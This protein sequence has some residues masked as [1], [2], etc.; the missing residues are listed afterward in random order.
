MHDNLQL[1]EVADSSST[2]GSIRSIPPHL[3]DEPTNESD[4]VE[5]IFRHHLEHHYDD[6][7]RLPLWFPTAVNLGSVGYIRHGQFI[8]LLDAHQP[9]LGVPSI[10]GDQVRSGTGGMDVD[11]RLP[12]RAFMSEFESLQTQVEDVEVRGVA[13]N[14]LDKAAVAW[15]KFIKGSGQTTESAS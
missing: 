11:N 14:A 1:P 3:N 15:T 8:K 9:P 12:P 6:R 5:R 4:V 13:L 2:S 10:L 7:L